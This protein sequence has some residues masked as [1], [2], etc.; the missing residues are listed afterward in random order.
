MQYNLVFLNAAHEE[1]NSKLFCSKVLIREEAA[2]F[3]DNVGIVIA[4]FP[5]SRVISITLAE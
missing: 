3:V 5:L 1:I 2:I 4:V